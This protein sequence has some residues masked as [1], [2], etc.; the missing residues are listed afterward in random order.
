MFKEIPHPTN[1]FQFLIGRLATLVYGF[2]DDF[3]GR[4]QFLIGRLATKESQRKAKERKKFQF[5]IGRLATMMKDDTYHCFF[6]VSIPY[7]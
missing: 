2:F 7:R 3:W 6:L 4:F 1:V 5:L